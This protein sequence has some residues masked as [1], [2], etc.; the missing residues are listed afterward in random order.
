[1]ATPPT[2]GVQTLVG[3]EGM[4][5]EAILTAGG[6]DEAPGRPAKP[7][8]ADTAAKYGLN[9]GCMANGFAPGNWEAADGGMPGKR[10][11]P[12]AA[13]AAKAACCC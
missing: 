9:A 8:A 6:I 11:W 1:M 3:I 10:L 12:P 7:P 5:A 4:L 2:G 13:A